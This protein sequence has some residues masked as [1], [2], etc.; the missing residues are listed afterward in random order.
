VFFRIFK[1][2]QRDLVIILKRR[3]YKK[4]KSIINEVDIS[5]NKNQL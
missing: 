4:E 5:S 1:E 2:W 3:T